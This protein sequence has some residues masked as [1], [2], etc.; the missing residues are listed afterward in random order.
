MATEI[1]DELVDQVLGKEFL[2][3]SV[4]D[5]I[6]CVCV[7]EKKNGKKKSVK[8]DVVDSIVIENKNSAKFKLKKM[9]FCCYKLQNDNATST[10]NADKTAQEKS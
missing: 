9:F 6:C 10:E 1:V 3:L 2:K 8:L 5:N 4:Q 7:C